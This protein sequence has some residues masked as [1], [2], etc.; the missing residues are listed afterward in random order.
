M[1]SFTDRFKAILLLYFSLL[2]VLVLNFCAVCTLVV[3]SYF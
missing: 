1:K 2:Y 3:F